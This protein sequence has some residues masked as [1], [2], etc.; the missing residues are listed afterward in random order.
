MF[1]W[2]IICVHNFSFFKRTVWTNYIQKTERDYAMHN[3]AITI[4]GN[5]DCKS[6]PGVVCFFVY[7][8]QL[9][10][11]FKQTPPLAFFLYTKINILGFDED[12]PDNGR[13]HHN[14][15]KNTY[16][17]GCSRLLLFEGLGRYDFLVV[18]DRRINRNCLGL[19]NNFG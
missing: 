16:L 7:T 17:V 4:W 12:R 14:W 11:R 5:L 8:F 18:R 6:G 13:A 9:N 19:F 3:K 2:L 15:S 10:I 1:L